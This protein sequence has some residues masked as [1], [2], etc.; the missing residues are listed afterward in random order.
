VRGGTVI[1]VKSAM[2]LAAGLGTRLRPVTETTPKALV[3]VKGR[4]LLDRALDQLEAVGVQRAVVNLHYKAELVRQHVRGR[5]RPRIGFSDEPELL[6]TGG[7]VAQALPQLGEPFFAVN[8]DA[9]WTDEGRQPALLRLARAF[10]PARHDAVLLVTKTAT[11]IG[12]EGPGDFLLD[13][14][15]RP[16]RRPE[17]E[18]VPFLYAGVQ[19]LSHRLFKGQPVAPFS[20]NRLWDRAIDEGRIIAVV[21]EGAWFDPGTLPGLALTE[22]RLAERRRTL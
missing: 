8:C 14:M 4:T 2:V 17:R 12:Y 9:V 16:M 21:H 13:P 15:G 20:I 18:V 6:D 22:E 5:D 1:A 19:L 7:G 11:A 10:D 3:P